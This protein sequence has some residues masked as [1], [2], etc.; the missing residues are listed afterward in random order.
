MFRA[1]RKLATLKQCDPY[2]LMP[3]CPYALMP[4]ALYLIP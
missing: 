2:A 3:L 4:Y 1:G